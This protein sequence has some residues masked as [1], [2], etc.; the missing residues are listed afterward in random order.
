MY[1]PEYCS[2]PHVVALN[3]MDLEVWTILVWAILKIQN[4]GRITVSGSNLLLFFN[5]RKPPL[6]LLPDKAENPKTL[7]TLCL[8]PGCWWAA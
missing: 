4:E 6:P 5:D 1:N 2:R 7:K 3:K 8:L